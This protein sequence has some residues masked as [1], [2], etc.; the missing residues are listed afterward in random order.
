[1][2]DKRAIKLFFGGLRKM[3]ERLYRRYADLNMNTYRRYH[4]RNS[5]GNKT[6]LYKR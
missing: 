6:I 5:K 2:N 1:M 4:K 3:G